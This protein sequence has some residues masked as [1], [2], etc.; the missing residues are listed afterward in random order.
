MKLRSLVSW[1]V[2][3]SLVLVVGLSACGSDDPAPTSTNNTAGSSS[4][5]ASGAGTAGTAGQSAAGSGGQAGAG[6]GGA[7]AAGSTS[8]AGGM[9][10]SCAAEA[11]CSECCL[12]KSP[13]GANKSFNLSLKHCGCAT[14]SPCKSVCDT[15]ACMGEDPKA[16]ITPKDLSMEC[17]ACLG[18]LP[19]SEACTVATKTEC[20]ADAACKEFASCTATCP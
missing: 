12:I 9:A 1:L 5:G 4:S 17:S 19:D 15:N 18:A 2:P 20:E 3:G 13:L 16:L 10:N 6:G 7:G 14:A 8:G 11:N